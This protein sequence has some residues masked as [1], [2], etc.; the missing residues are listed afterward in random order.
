MT[1]QCSGITLKGDQ[2]CRKMLTGQYCYLHIDTNHPEMI[3]CCVCYNKTVN[4]L[5]CT[6]YLCNKCVNKME[7][8]TCPLCRKKLQGKHITKSNLN[9]I[10]TIM[11]LNN[12]DI[13]D[14]DDDEKTDRIINIIIDENIP[15][16]DAMIDFIFY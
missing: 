14:N 15:F 4:I 11:I 16:D 6:H 8:D 13:L 12:P 7:T 10:Q 2:C 3:E 1:Q 9:K 5:D